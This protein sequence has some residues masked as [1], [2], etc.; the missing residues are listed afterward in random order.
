MSFA[1]IILVQTEQLLTT[2]GWKCVSLEYRMTIPSGNAFFFFFFE[3]AHVCPQEKRT[4][5]LAWLEAIMLSNAQATA[6]FLAVLIKLA[7]ATTVMRTK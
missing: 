6:A 5:W 2:E 3:V 7:F 4:G 1:D